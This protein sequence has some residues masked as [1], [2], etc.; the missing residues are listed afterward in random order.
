MNKKL[1]VRVGCDYMGKPV[2]YSVFGMSV[3]KFE[4]ISYEKRLWP[5]F[6]LAQK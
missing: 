5:E 4:I 6:G 3:F 2:H 1:N